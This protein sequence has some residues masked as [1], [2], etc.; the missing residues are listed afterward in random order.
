[1]N[2]QS[3]TESAHASELDIENA[4]GLEKDRLLRMMHGSN[5]F[6]E[7]NRSFE[8]RLQGRVIHDFVVRQRLLD[9]HQPIFIQLSQVVCIRQRVSRVRI[10]HQPDRGKMR[11]NF[12]HNVHIPAGLDFDLDALIARGDF[13]LDSVQKIA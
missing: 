12:F 9:H 3:L 4:A 1:M 5:T 6:V 10:C 7:A 8:L 2:P 13:L 11:A